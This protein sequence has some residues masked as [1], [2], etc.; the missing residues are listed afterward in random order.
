MSTSSIA[1]L[2]APVP[3]RVLHSS[4]ICAA[5]GTMRPRPTCFMA[6]T[7]STGTCGQNWS[8]SLKFFS[9]AACSLRPTRSILFTRIMKGVLRSSNRSMSRLSCAVTP[10]SASM[11]YS[12]TSA[13]VVVLSEELTEKRSTVS[14]MR[15]RRG[16]PAACP[17]TRRPARR[18]R[19]ECPRCRASSRPHR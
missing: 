8:T 14:V 11:T 2:S 16:T 6:E 17:R 5:S 13:L 1:R 18:S 9:S 7:I 15:V 12:V 3:M 19:R 10:S 4:R